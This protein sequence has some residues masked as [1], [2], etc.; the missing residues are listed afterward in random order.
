VQVSKQGLKLSFKTLIG[1]GKFHGTSILW[2]CPQ[3]AKQA[4]NGGIKRLYFLA[5]DGLSLKIISEEIISCFTIILRLNIYILLDSQLISHRFFVSQR[6]ASSGFSKEM[7]NG[8][9]LIL[10][11]LHFK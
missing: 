1:L 6:V 5:R 3:F 7:D 2:F 11:R 8:L 4:V 10:Q 9:L